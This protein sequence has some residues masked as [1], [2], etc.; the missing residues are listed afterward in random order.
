MFEIFVGPFAENDL[1]SSMICICIDQNE[2]H[3]FETG[4]TLPG[5]SVGLTTL[6]WLTFSRVLKWI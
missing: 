1:V 2:K 4:R 6:I 5:L 3:N